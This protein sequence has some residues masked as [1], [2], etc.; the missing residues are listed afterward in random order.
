MVPAEWLALFPAGGDLAWPSFGLTGFGR[1]VRPAPGRSA[2][3][4]APGWVTCSTTGDGSFLLTAAGPAELSDFAL[5]VYRHVT[6]PARP[7]HDRAVPHGRRAARVP[8]STPPPA[9]VGSACRTW[10]RTGPP[11]GSAASSAGRVPS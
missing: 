11:P 8:S 6:D 10:P 4:R 5:A 9:S 2:S 7:A 1:R 3:R